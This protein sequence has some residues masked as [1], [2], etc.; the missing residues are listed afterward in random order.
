MTF[1]QKKT[2]VIKT[3]MT[4]I[5]K[6]YL[7]ALIKRTLLL[8]YVDYKTRVLNIHSSE[9]KFLLEKSQKNRKTLSSKVQLLVVKC[10]SNS[11]L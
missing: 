11:K 5:F 2:S 3:H 4:N 6:T 9:T 1:D 8:T 10:S 7:I